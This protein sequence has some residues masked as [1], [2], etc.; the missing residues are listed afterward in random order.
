M[1]L[2]AQ[3]H[4]VS[5]VV[6]SFKDIVAYGIDAFV[7]P[8]LDPDGHDN[9]DVIWDE[10]VPKSSSDITFELAESA[11]ADPVWEPGDINSEYFTGIMVSTPKEIYSRRT[12]MTLA[13]HPNG[14]Y[15]RAAADWFPMDFLKINI[16]KR[17]FAAQESAIL[18]GISTPAM[19]NDTS[20]AE[21]LPGAQTYE[22]L[23]MKYIDQTQEHMLDLQT[24]LFTEGTGTFGLDEAEDFLEQ[25]VADW[26]LV[27]Q[28]AAFV[29]MV[30]DIF[31]TGNARVVVPGERT[32]GVIAPGT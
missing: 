15:D 18:I 5:T 6:I 1:G 27:D 26:N 29:P 17:Y 22:W 13:S 10:L 7:L 31:G 25:L 4:I 16:D 32:V 12:W 28:A 8:L 2:D 3:L 11:D 24:G 20:D 14:T 19:D 9:L 23:L 30:S 21:L